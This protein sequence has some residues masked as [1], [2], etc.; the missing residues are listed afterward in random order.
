M[1]PQQGHLIIQLTFTHTQ[2]LPTT[3]SF[4]HLYV[5]LALNPV[6]RGMVDGRLKD[7]LIRYSIPTLAMPTPREHHGINIG[8]ADILATLT[9]TSDISDAIAD[10][11]AADTSTPAPA[12]PSPTSPTPTPT[13]PAL[14]PTSTSVSSHHRHADRVA[15]DAVAYGN[16]RRNR[17]RYRQELQR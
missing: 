7:T 16:R 13:T 15:N 8:T 17:R 9:F 10:D 11:S 4:S 5:T 3:T 6:A 12:T 14:W 2:L 1:A